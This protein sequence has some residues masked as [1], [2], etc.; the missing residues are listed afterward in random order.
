[1]IL[2]PKQTESLEAIMA[3]RK[4]KHLTKNWNEAI[5]GDSLAFLKV[6]KK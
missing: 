1:M 5:N 6:L 2:I 4:Q 3:S